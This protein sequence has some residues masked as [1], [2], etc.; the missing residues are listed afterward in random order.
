MT[1]LY[2]SRRKTTPV[3]TAK[4]T[5][6][7]KSKTQKTKSEKEQLKVVL[8]KNR[9]VI[10]YLVDLVSYN[11]FSKA[12]EIL[13]ELNK[14]GIDISIHKLRRFLTAANITKVANGKGLK[15][16]KLSLMQNRL[17]LESKVETLVMSIQ[18]NAVC[19]LIKTV[20]AGAQIIAKICDSSADDLEILGTIAGDDV[21]ML[22]PKDVS[23][24]ERV[25]KRTK[26][27][28]KL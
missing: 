13:K 6:T 24:I 12:T 18:S 4:I 14:N 11:N 5:T 23:E 1:K 25:E 7:K 19:I 8:E 27:L 10:N 2:V 26:M 28:F 17:T 22:I 16:Y 15:Y 20:P 21:V 3:P 9:S